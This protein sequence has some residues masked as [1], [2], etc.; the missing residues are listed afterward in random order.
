MECHATWTST[1]TCSTSITKTPTPPPSNQTLPPSPAC[2]AYFRW[3]H[4]DLHPWKTTGISQEAVQSAAK[5][6]NFR[7]VVINGRAYVEHYHG[8]FQTRDVFT[9][10]GILQLLNRYPGRVPD[11]DLMFNCD[12]MPVVRSADYPTPPAPPLFRY[13]K[14]DTTLD[15]V[16][17]DW[18][19]WG[20]PEINIKPWVTLMPEMAEGNKR[21]KWV[22]REP[23]AYW[24]GNSHVAPSREELMKCNVSK[25]GD[26]NARLYNNDWDKEIKMGF[27]GTNLADQCLN[28]YKIYIEGRSW[29]VS[30]KYI[31]AC[32][33]PTLLM[34]TGFH[35]FFTRGLMPGKH[36]WPIR[37]ALDREKCR[38]IKFAVDW[39][40]TH[41]QKAQA[42][43]K[44]GSRF[45]Q[46]KINMDF[47][48]DYML[49][50]ITEYAKL[51]NYKPYI[52]EKAVEMCLQS[53]AC[54]S[55]GRQRMFMVDSMVK[56]PH[57][58]SPCTMP[59]PFNSTEMKEL[60]AR[61]AE[62]INQV[63]KWEKEAWERKGPKL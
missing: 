17:P 47:V 28:R 40:N 34:R 9:L 44:E 63:E 54:P 43:G 10:W 57:N 8:A 1:A 48:Y 25:D 42:I 4:E 3:I 60:I 52:P 26:W 7:L 55:E 15:I 45:I 24:K 59:P 16:F 37:N 2:P 6:A 36:Y 22:D 50:L 32:D 39:G 18:S 58:A 13:C 12:D 21:V 29:S 56:S 23:Y 27:K 49:H 46:E 30:G 5:L 20:W 62:S 33:S 35:D 38:S 41:K 61:K 53:L 14:D 19:F 31:L 11:F 51:L